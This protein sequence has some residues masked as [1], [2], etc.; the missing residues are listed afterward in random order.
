MFNFA[1]KLK[2]LRTSLRTWNATAVGNI[3]DNLLR[4]EEEMKAKELAF[5]AS[6]QDADLVQ[7]NRCQAIYFKALADEESY[8]KQKARVKWLAEGDHNTKFFHATVQERRARMTV[9][10]IKDASGGWLDDQDA[11]KAH[12]LDFFRDLL[13]EASNTP[14]AEAIDSVLQHIPPLVTLQDNQM[15]LRPLELSEIRSAVFSLDP[16]SAPGPD[17]FTGVFFRHCWDIIATDLLAA[18]QEFM[19]G[20]P[21]RSACQ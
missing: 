21:P 15:L 5:Q 9:H 12:A 2:R 16:D 11:I 19:A 13:S 7:L 18:A 3:F 1:L 20:V 17:G 6:R 14:D 4:A 8:W 10:R